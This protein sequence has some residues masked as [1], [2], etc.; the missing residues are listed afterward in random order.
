[1]LTLSYGYKKPEDT[2]TGDVVFPALEAN[3][4]QVNDHAHNGVNSAPLTSQ[5]RQALAASW[6]AAPIG[7]GVYRQNVIAPTNYSW[8]TAQF[9]VRLSTGEIVYPDLEVVDATNMFVYTND[10]TVQYTIFVR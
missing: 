2:D 6:V 3:W 5:T 1:M 7:G 4:Q 9:Q 8:L 10:N